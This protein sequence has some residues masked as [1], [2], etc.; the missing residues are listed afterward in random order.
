MLDRVGQDIGKSTRWTML[1]ELRQLHVQV[2]TKTRALGIEQDAVRV[3][4]EGEESR[5]P[6]DSVVLALGSASFNPLQDELQSLGLN[7]RV[8]GDAREVGQAI[9][10]IHAGFALGRDI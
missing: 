8:V 7:A 3:D 9:D 4:K 6:A 2:K 5:I 10:A 1:Q